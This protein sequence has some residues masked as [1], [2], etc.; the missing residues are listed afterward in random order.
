MIGVCQA[1]IE[2]STFLKLSFTQYTVPPVVFATLCFWSVW[3][4]EY[5]AYADTSAPVAVTITNFPCIY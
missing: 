4:L 3:Y 2:Y 1:I 5:L